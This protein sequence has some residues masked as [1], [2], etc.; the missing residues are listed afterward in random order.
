MGDQVWIYISKERLQGEVQNIKPIIYGIFKILDKIGN[1]AFRLDLPPCMQ[2][3]AVVNVEKL[4]LYEPP[5]IED[6]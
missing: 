5:M 6:Q 2:I 3:Y 1:N 4:I